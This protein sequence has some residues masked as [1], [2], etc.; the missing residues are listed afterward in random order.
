NTGL[1]LK[2]RKAPLNMDAKTF[3]KNGYSLIDGIASFLESLPKRPVTTAKQPK[4]IRSLLGETTLPF[5]GTK[6]E[7]IFGDAMELLFEHSLFNGSP[8]FWGYITS[9][10]APA[11][12]LAELLASAVNAN[13][14]AYILSPVATE[15]EK[16]VI[17]WI[18]ELIGFTQTCGGLFVSGGNM[19]NITGLL[20]ARKAKA[21][22]DIRQTGL[23]DKRMLIYCSSGTH[24]WINKAADLLGF[25]TNNIRWIE[26][27]GQ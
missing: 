14:G 10:A 26:M 8:R 17:R 20:V 16:Q 6:E 18:A 19:A 25:G 12:M 15:I 24:T 1:L 5:H 7:E 22:W 4:E 21:S 3:R 11:G 23:G 2:Q 13:V 9:S 27:N